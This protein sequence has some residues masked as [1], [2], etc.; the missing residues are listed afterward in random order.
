MGDGAGELNDNRDPPVGAP[1]RST[2]RI[3][4]FESLLE[5]PNGLRSLPR[6]LPCDAR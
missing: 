2:G 6:G 1:N 5:S 4:P 3:T